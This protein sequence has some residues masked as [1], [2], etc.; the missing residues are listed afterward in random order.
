M[1]SLNS[2]HLN[3]LRTV[4]AVARTGALQAAADELGVTPS[5]VSQQLA[6]TEAQIGR[7]LFERTRN[8]LTLTE[9]GRQFAERLTEG[10]RTLAGAVALADDSTSNTLVVS[11]APAFA[12][13]WLVPRLSSFQQAHPEIHLRIDATTNVVDLDR[14]DIDLAIRMGSGTWPNVHAELL[15]AQEVFPVC[16]PALAEKL[17]VPADIVKLPVIADENTMFSWDRWF[18]KAGVAKP[19]FVP[20]GPS[21]TDPI[22]GIDAAVAGQG[23]TLAW[24]ILA[25]DHLAAGRLVAPFGITATSGL[26]YHLV[27]SLAKRPGK[28]VSVFRAWLVREVACTMNW[29]D[30]LRQT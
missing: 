24:P 26:G 10:F 9:F 22:L 27:T 29:F 6:R 5:A 25:A 11:V 21:F 13:R 14:S 16:A 18:E 12:L 19:S 3:G 20:A 8:G 7:T 17:K 23:V 2:V 30:G 4:E 1:K 28:K 15:L